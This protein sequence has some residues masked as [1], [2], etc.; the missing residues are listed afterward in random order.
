[1]QPYLE[2]RR[3]GGKI[4]EAR[5]LQK[6]DAFIHLKLI[7]ISMQRKEF[8]PPERPTTLAPE[9][10]NAGVALSLHPCGWCCS[11]EGENLRQIG[12]PEQFK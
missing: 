2:G 6:R 3:E 11:E 5:G 9:T 1:M 8:Q 4:H 7:I 10:L 12:N